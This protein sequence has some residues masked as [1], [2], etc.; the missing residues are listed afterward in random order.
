MMYE[1]AGACGEVRDPQDVVARAQAWAAGHRAEVL[2]ADAS[3]VFGRDHL[4]S[5]VRHAMRARDHGTGVARDLGLET[6]RYLCAR[7]QV[8]D[9]IRVGGLKAGTTAM[10]VVAFG[11]PAADLLAHLGWTRDDGA[12]SAEGKSL[13]VLGVHGR[14]RET[15]PSERTADLAL[16]RTALVDLEK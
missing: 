10:A 6:L 5:A 2:L 14:E 7:R 15:V 11:A 1:I 13:S 12:L 4:E 9:A 8:A 16:E 3:V